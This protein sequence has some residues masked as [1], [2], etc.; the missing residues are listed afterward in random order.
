MSKAVFLDTSAW[1][2]LTNKSDTFHAKAKK[3]RSKLLKAKSKCYVTDYVIVEIANALIGTTDFSEYLEIAKE[4]NFQIMNVVE[5]AGAS[6]AFPSQTMY[7]ETGTEG[8]D[9]L[10]RKSDVRKTL[11]KD[12]LMSFFILLLPFDCFRDG[13]GLNA[14]RIKMR[15]GAAILI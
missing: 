5:K 12:T 8:S 15:S 11:M 10:S 6:F 2:A 7:L 14:L 13:S 3:A 1:L 9:I 4:L